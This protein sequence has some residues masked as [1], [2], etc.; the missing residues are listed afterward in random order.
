MERSPTFGIYDST[1][2]T[3][4]LQGSVT[5]TAGGGDMTLDAVAL[6]I[7]QQTVI[8]TFTIVDGNT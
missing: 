4:H 3:C 7:G 6:T 2:T 5:I 8:T 1:E